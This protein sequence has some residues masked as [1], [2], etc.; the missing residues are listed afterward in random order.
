MKK[1]GIDRRAYRAVTT[2]RRSTDDSAWV[3]HL[4]A[5]ER[6]HADLSKEAAAS[7]EFLKT[8]T[9][10]R[11]SGSLLE[12]L[13]D[14]GMKPSPLIPN[15]PHHQRTISRTMKFLVA[16]EEAEELEVDGSEMDSDPEPVSPGSGIF[17][18]MLSI[19]NGSPDE[20]AS[21][22]ESGENYGT[23]DQPPRRGR[24]RRIWINYFRRV[25]QPVV[26]QESI[27]DFLYT[28]VLCRIL[29]L[30]VLSAILYYGLGN[31]KFEFDGQVTYSWLLLFAAR[32]IVTYNLARA[33]EYLLID[34][35]AH[36]SSFISRFF[37][38][39]VTLVLIQCKDEELVVTPFLWC[40]WA[41]WDILLLR[42]PDQFSGHWLY[43]TGIGIFTD[44]NPT[45][46][47]EENPYYT[48]LLVSIVII[49]VFVAVKRLLVS[50]AQ[51]NR[52]FAMYK[53]RLDRLTEC[54]AIL[55][56]LA[57]LAEE[58]HDKP[59]NE[60]VPTEEPNEENEK[61][62]LSPKERLK[63]AVGKLKVKPSEEDLFGQKEEIQDAEGPLVPNW[64]RF[65]E[66]WTEPNQLN[67]EKPSLRILLDFRK[68]MKKLFGQYPFSN[69]FGPADTRKNCIE[70]A[71][72]VFV[73]LLR[74]TPRED[75]LPYATLLRIF[76]SNSSMLGNMVEMEKQEDAEKKLLSTLFRTESDGKIRLLSFL[77]SVDTGTSPKYRLSAF[78]GASYP[79]R[80]AVA[81][82]CSIP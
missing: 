36:R 57:L 26:I 69:A 64:M 6:P 35:L 9:R 15:H 18:G 29:A 22:L 45:G 40:A 50:L 17:S 34:C 55:S 70:S 76:E 1:R 79:G 16:T 49:S 19:F 33:T 37:G 31:P 80:P 68:A 41:L 28:V 30:V 32:Q 62:K 52:T 14:I 58:G 3:E 20:R 10:H 56:K 8:E 61:A 38:P 75:Y 23:Q 65:L 24:R 82:F 39:L 54:S 71:Q 81:L 59:I 21:L 48:K 7:I 53:S 13:Q 5:A 42:G 51:G 60:E 11:R 73:G 27:I 25:F 72:H 66:S 67:H 77:Q 74:W 47:F 44:Q 46:G 2:R 63:S 78:H 43:F 12:Q 4:D